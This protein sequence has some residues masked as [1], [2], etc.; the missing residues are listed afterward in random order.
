DVVAIALPEA[1]LLVVH[2]PQTLDPLGAL[3]EI[4]V[5][6][7]QARRPSVLPWQRLTLM[8]RHH[9]RLAGGQALDSHVG[10]V[11]PLRVGARVRVPRLSPLE[12]EVHRHPTEVRAELRPLGDA[13]DVCWDRLPGERVELLPGPLSLARDHA[14]DPECP[15][16]RSDV[17]G[18][19]GGE[20]GEPV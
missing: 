16:V 5:G 13:V 9:P 8:L 3:P 6:D 14:I 12:Q 15:F 7:E 11:A 20:N 18:W 19:T 4:E 2:Y 1:R 17:G 10:C